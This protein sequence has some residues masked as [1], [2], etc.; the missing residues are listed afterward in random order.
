L[1][2]LVIEKKQILPPIIRELVNSNSYKKSKKFQRYFE[3]EAKIVGEVKNMI[4]IEIKHYAYNTQAHGCQGLL[5]LLLNPNTGKT[6]VQGSESF[7]AL[8]E[9]KFMGK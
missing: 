2:G 9:K 1:K 3:L 8:A 6:I 5:F 4:D 7:G